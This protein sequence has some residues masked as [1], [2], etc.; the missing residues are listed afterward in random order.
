[1]SPHRTSSL[2]PECC[3]GGGVHPR[4]P[5]AAVSAQRANELT[6]L[7]GVPMRAY[8]S[9]SSAP[10]TVGGVQLTPGHTYAKLLLTAAGSE[11]EALAA[12]KG[13]DAE[14]GRPA[15]RPLDWAR[16]TRSW[17][18][19]GSCGHGR[20]RAETG[21]RTLTRRQLTLLSQAPGDAAG[22]TSTRE[23]TKSKQRMGA[24]P[25]LEVLLRGAVVEDEREGG[26]GARGAGDGVRR[27]RLADSRG[28]W[29]QPPAQ[30]RYPSARAGAAGR[31]R[32]AARALM[33]SG[34]QQPK[35]GLQDDGLLP[36]RAHERAAADEIQPLAAEGVS[37]REGRGAPV[38][39]QDLLGRP[40]GG[41]KWV[42]AGRPTV[43]LGK[44]WR[45]GGGRRR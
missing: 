17:R 44:H 40:G 20:T 4:A 32:A 36:T 6:H 28:H 2:S 1:M 15:E 14:G 26:L 39:G 33:Q 7:K 22:E 34:K 11:E 35:A 31:R 12:Q 3:C 18:A 43:A 24:R 9:F 10:R 38:C 23:T 27:V 42:T 13:G 21:G 25:L 45:R 5:S 19:L 30:R 29:R 16:R 41:E 8:P 37:V